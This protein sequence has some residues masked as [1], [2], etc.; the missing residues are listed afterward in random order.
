[1]V[2]AVASQPE[3]PRF[4]NAEVAEPQT[5]SRMVPKASKHIELDSLRASQ[6]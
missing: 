4:G 6:R 1:M 3:D 5:S 2:S